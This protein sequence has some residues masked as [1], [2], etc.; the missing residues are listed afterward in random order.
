V[1][2]VGPLHL[3]IAHKIICSA[4]C[5]QED[6]GSLDLNDENKE[7]DFAEEMDPERARIEFLKSFLGITDKHDKYYH[8]EE[9]ESPSTDPKVLLESFDKEIA[10]AETESAILYL[11]VWKG[12][13]TE[14]F[15]KLPTEE[16]IMIA[17]VMK[18]GLL[19]TFEEY[20]KNKLE[21]ETEEQKAFFLEIQ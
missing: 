15:E 3:V 14:F 6:H 17:S 19:P 2:R 18:F 11:H 5:Q 1:E 16:E 8:N 21:S 4:T 12:V 10:K 20:R 7:N 9:K 13:V